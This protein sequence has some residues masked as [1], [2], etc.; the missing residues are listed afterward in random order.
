MKERYELPGEPPCPVIRRGGQA[1]VE[2][3]RSV[4]E[5]VFSHL[6][7][8]GRIL[9]G[10]L[11]HEGVVTHVAELDGRAIGYTMLGFYP[12]ARNEYV[13]DLLA[14]AVAPGAQGRGIGKQLLEHALIEARAARRR[15]PVRE[16]RLSVADSNMRARKLF[17]QFGF[18]LMDGDHGLYDGG[19]VALHMCRKL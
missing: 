1:D 15:L 17:A 14:I 16:L 5:Q 13:A 11:A 8:Y 2:F 9:P 4:A 18:R 12:V 6:G 19:Q 3:I 10:W 7:D